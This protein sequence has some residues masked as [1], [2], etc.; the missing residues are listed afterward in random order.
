MTGL[1]V[2][3][4]QKEKI[5]G[6]SLVSKGYNFSRVVSNCRSELWGQF[7]LHNSSC[8]RIARDSCKQKLY[9]VNLP[10]EV[11]PR[12]LQTLAVT[13]VVIPGV[14]VMRE[15]VCIECERLINAEVPIPTTNTT[16]L[17]STQN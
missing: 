6:K 16:E 13:V 11:L 17:K 12:L 9:S 5:A 3:I 4:G 14:M 8:K 1:L 2:H 15:T 7:T 10:Y